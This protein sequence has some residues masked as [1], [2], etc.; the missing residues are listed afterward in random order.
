MGEQQLDDGG[1]LGCWAVVGNVMQPALGLREEVLPKL[2]D[3]SAANQ[4]VRNNNF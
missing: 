3:S 1:G 2:Q 4:Y